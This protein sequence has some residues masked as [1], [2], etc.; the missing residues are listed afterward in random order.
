MACQRGDGSNPQVP[1]GGL[2]QP[3]TQGPDNTHKRHFSA[4]GPHTDQLCSGNIVKKR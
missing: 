2:C 1:H 4:W 3:V